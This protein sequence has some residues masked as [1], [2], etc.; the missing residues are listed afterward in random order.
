MSVTVVGSL[1]EDVLVAGERLPV[2]Q[3]PGEVVVEVCPNPGDVVLGAN[4]FYCR[5]AEHSVP[6]YQLAWPHP[7]GRYP[8]DEGYRCPPGCQPRPGTW[9]A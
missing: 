8:W 9:E 7:D 3:G 2:G 5:P 1:N 4:R 6:A